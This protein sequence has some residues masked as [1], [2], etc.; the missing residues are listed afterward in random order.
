MTYTEIFAQFS[1]KCSAYWNIEIIIKLLHLHKPHEYG[2]IFLES[3]NYDYSKRGP[4]IY[5]ITFMF[6]NYSNST[7]IIYRKYTVI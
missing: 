6:Y 1:N 4:C 2:L 5:Q 7:Y 3:H